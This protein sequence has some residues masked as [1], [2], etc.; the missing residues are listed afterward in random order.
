V[1]E[2]VEMITEGP[3]FIGSDYKESAP[4][5]NMDETI[6]REAELDALTLGNDLFR[7][8]NKSGPSSKKRKYDINIYGCDFSVSI[9]WKK[10]IINFYS[11]ATITA[12]KNFLDKP[13]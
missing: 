7:T 8:Y 9:T 11:R 12:N 13:I 1:I 4:F 3:I 2:D 5:S 10:N 6:I